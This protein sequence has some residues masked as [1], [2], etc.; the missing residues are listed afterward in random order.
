MKSKNIRVPLTEEHKQKISETTKG[1]S[2]FPLKYR[3]WRKVRKTNYCWWWEGVRKNGGYGNITV[4]GK[5]VAVH[6]VSWELHNG[7]IPQGMIVRHYICDNPAC[8]NPAHLRLGTR[9]QNSQDKVSKRRQAKGSDLS[10]LTEQDV[11]DIRESYRKGNTPKY[12]AEHYDMSAQGIIMMLTG[13]NWKHVAEKDGG[14][15][16]AKYG[17]KR[18]KENI[19]NSQRGKSLTEDH[20]QKLRKAAKK[21]WETDT[22]WNKGIPM[23]D[24]TRAK[25]SNSCKGQHRTFTKEHRE[26]ISKA[27]KGMK[28]TDEHRKN[29]SL[30]HKKGII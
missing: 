30:A 10:K 6:R 2:K 5:Q 7:P 18:W 20:K 1:K 29:L 15:I 26:A 3:F 4:N 12:L 17:S 19:S 8:V 23:S 11:L 16:A 22:P 14:N 24:E 28:F 25:V 27:R 21:R 9:K 13:E